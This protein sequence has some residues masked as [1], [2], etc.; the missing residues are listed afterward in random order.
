MWRLPLLKHERMPHDVVFLLGVYI[1]WKSGMSVRLINFITENTI[2]IF[3][4]P[5]AIEGC[6]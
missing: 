6:A 4:K 1:I 3:F 5:Y 2:Y